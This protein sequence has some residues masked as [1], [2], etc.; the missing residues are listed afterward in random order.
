ML[1][2]RSICTSILLTAFVNKSIRTVLVCMRVSLKAWHH[3]TVSIFPPAG[4][5]EAASL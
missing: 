4:G 2:V 5:V 3:S 1:S